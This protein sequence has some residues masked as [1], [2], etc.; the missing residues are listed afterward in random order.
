MCTP[1]V[2]YL[3]S[4]EYTDMICRISELYFHGALS[5]IIS[6]LTCRV[7]LSLVTTLVMMRGRP[8]DRLVTDDVTSDRW[9]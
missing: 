1:T 9:I 5:H 4:V 6:V 8:A 7:L 3:F 2:R